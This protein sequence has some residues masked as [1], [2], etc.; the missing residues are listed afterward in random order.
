MK[1][2]ARLPETIEI[3]GKTGSGMVADCWF[4]A[5]TP[6]LVVGVWAGLPNNE[7]RLEMEHGFTGGKIAAPVAVRFFQV[8]Q[9]PKPDLLA[10]KN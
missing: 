4:F 2:P 3:S 7:I 1:R 5:V 10:Q 8:L 9:K 6:K